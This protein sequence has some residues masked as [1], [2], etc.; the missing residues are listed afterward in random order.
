MADAPSQC[1]TPSSPQRPAKI[2]RPHPHHERF[3]TRPL[4]IPPPSPHLHPHRHRH[5]PRHHQLHECPSHGL[6]SPPP[7]DLR[8]LEVIYLSSPAPSIRPYLYA[9]H[10]SPKPPS[11]A[12]TRGGFALSNSCR[13]CVKICKSVN[14]LSLSA[15]QHH[16]EDSSQ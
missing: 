9:L 11:V 7:H 14:L 1:L 15:T 6:T 3:Q 8:D 5:R 16:K 13:Y 2:G 12:M 10:P 4:E